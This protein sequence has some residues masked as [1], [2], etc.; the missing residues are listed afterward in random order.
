MDRIQSVVLIDG[1]MRRRAAISRKLRNGGKHVE[2]FESIS[3]LTLVWPH[4]GLV[5][6]HDEGGTI[7]ALV[8]QMGSTGTWLPVIAYAESP[9][10]D[11]VARAI[12]AGAIGYIAWPFEDAE[13]AEALDK[14]Q[15]RAKTLG[16]RR[17]RETAARSRIELLTRRERE[18]LTGVADGLSN[19]MIGQKLGISPRTVEIHRSNLLTKMGLHRSSE[20][21][22]IAV[23]ASLLK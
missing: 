18:V 1:A 8:A 20:A 17:L 22:R 14:A 12:L 10:P 7:G 23:E 19:R 3:D 4:S 9:S 5:L 16:R 13:L 6:A 21:I 15:D 2:P 11:R